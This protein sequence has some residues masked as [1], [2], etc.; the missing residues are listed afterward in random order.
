[1]SSS[2][3]G[4]DNAVNELMELA[5]QDNVDIPVPQIPPL[6]QCLSTQTQDSTGNKGVAR[7]GLRRAKESM[8]THKTKT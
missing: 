2:V 5:D 1:V 7:A 6:C 8:K 3:G 4:E